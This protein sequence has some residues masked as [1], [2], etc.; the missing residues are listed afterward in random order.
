[1]S[2]K[3]AGAALGE[4]I[5]LGL[6]IGPRVKEH[7]FVIAANGDAM[8]RLGEVD[9]ILDICKKPTRVGGGR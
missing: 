8:W 7:L 6:W 2:C 3:G 4:P 5:S 1:M 9:E